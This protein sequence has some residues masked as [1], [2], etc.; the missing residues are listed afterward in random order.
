MNAH[1]NC[2]N[3]VCVVLHS[4]PCTSQKMITCNQ[5]HHAVELFQLTMELEE[6]RY[7][8]EEYDHKQCPPR[9]T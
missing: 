7:L 4:G 8:G 3:N 2:Q 1:I 6:W 5:F 9:V